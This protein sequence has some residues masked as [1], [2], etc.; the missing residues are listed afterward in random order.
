MNVLAEFCV[1]CQVCQSHGTSVLQDFSFFYKIAIF[2]KHTAIIVVANI[3]KD[4]RCT[5]VL[6]DGGWIFSVM[7]NGADVGSVTSTAM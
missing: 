1:T 7:Y 4:E 6:A 3:D 2:S 5:D